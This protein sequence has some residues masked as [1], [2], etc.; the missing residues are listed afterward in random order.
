M[1]RVVFKYTARMIETHIV[2][3]GGRVL[4][5]AGQGDVPCVWIEVGGEVA[6]EEERTFQMVGTGHPVPESATYLGTAHCGPFV[7]H[8]YELTAPPETT[9]EG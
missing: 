5:V 1:S 3:V 9:E 8:V 2:P 7:W 6:V 4:H